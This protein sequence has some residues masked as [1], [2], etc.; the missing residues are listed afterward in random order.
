MCNLLQEKKNN[1]NEKCDCVKCSLSEDSEQLTHQYFLE[2]Q[3]QQGETLLNKISVNNFHL[4][5]C[6]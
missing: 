3:R 1:F 6:L 5:R 2:A 4:N